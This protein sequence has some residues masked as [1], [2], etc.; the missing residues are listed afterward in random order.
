[1]SIWTW[2]CK[3]D[4]CHRGDSAV[5]DARKARIIP[6]VSKRKWRRICAQCV[7]LEISP[8]V[9]FLSVRVSAQ[10]RRYGSSWQV[11]RQALQTSELTVRALKELTDEQG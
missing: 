7:L 6:A 8:D 9:C 4:L 3:P 11:L 2:P 1:M 10:L 5:A